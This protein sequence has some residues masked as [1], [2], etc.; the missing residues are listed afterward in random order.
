MR[1]LSFHRMVATTLFTILSVTM[2]SAQE[3]TRKFS[4]QHPK[5]DEVI[6]P[7]HTVQESYS[8]PLPHMYL[9]TTQLPRSF[10]WGHTD[11][12]RSYLT[13]SLN[14][15]IPQY[16]G[17]CWAHAAVSSLGDRIQIAH[18]L[19]RDPNK[20]ED[21]VWMDEFNL[22]V[23]FIL[24]CGADM[25][26]SCHGGSTSGAFQ[27]IQTRGY[28][29]VDTC[30][31]Y[32]ACSGEEQHNS[33]FGPLCSHVDTSCTPLNTCRTCA[34]NGD[35]RPIA[36]FP[37]ASI[38]EYGIYHWPTVAMIQAEIWMRGP[39]KTSLD[40]TLIQDYPGGVLWNASQY[41]TDQHNHGVSIVGW[42]YDEE[43]QRQYWI[44]RMISIFWSPCVLEIGR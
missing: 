7:G 4:Y 27:L 42:G 44:V 20:N 25:A 29:P 3:E 30:Q 9:D 13:N 35:C 21:D 12:G 1:L 24:N 14:Q 40:A 10:S 38:A 34:P 43:K 2:I 17:S 26:G 18:G 33:S 5:H 19:H 28:I 39:V 6:L 8:L 15:H 32:L 23:Q 31:P 16:C 36:Q 11:K 37:N 41:H 22:S